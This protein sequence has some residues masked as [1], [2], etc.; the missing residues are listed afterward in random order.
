MNNIS[1]NKRIAKNTILLYA[2]TIVVLIISLY[3]SRLIL[4]ALGVED[5][6]IYNVV[7]GIVALMSFFRSSLSKSTSRFITYEIGS[8]SDNSCQARVFSAA[9]S[10]HVI[11]VIAVLLIGESLGLLILRYWTDIPETRHRAA[12]W[13]YQCVLIIFCLQ[14]L[15]APYES[16]IIAHE[17]M[18]VFACLTILAALL[19]LGIVYVLFYGGCDRLISY[20]VLMVI[21]DIILFVCYW[22]YDHYH[23]PVYRFQFIWDSDYSKRIFSFSG[24]TFLGSSVNAG[25]QQGV[26]LLFNNFVGLVAN[27]ALGFAN[28]VNGAVSQFISSF[29]V[30]FNPQIIKLF[31]QHEL[32]QMHL[33]ISRASKFSFILAYVLALPLIANMDFVLQIWLSEV[34]QYTIEFCKLILVCSVIDATTGVFNTAIT[35]T[36]NIRGFQIGISISFL[37]DLIAAATLLMMHF[38]PAFVFGSR[39]LTRGLINMCIELYFV[40][41][42][43]SFNLLQ[44]GK[45]VLLPIC[46]TVLITMPLMLV[47]KH[48][49]SGWLAL[50]FSCGASLASIVVLVYFLFL[51]KIEKIAV[52]NLLIQKDDKS[53]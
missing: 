8:H 1:N 25:T 20:G 48:T 26:S 3:T 44:Y 18:S 36:G 7:G 21:V 49:F 34:P 51:S 15:T 38:H 33:L 50:I 39:I 10:I 28:Q 4:K 17:K 12:F 43:L 13:V 11:I 45:D 14:I 19:K 6:G 5:L 46:L 37:L 29:Q 30:A 24:W 9:M 41:K 2:R 52:R 16:I 42:Q 40:K 32:Q 23:F 22:G 31:A 47:I 53:E 35:A 27:T